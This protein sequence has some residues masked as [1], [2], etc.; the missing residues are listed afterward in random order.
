MM[1]YPSPLPPRLP[2]GTR[3]RH[4]TPFTARQTVHLSGGSYLGDWGEIGCGRCVGIEAGYI[5]WSS[6]PTVVDDTMLEFMTVEQASKPA[7]GK[8]A[9]CPATAELN[10]DGNCVYC[11]RRLANRSAQ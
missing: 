9:S 5:D 7:S 2:D 11:A 10:A 8:C 1:A 4:S 6:V 3:S